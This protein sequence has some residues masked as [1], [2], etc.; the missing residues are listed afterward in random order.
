MI[1]GGGIGGL[2]AANALIRQGLRVSVYEQAAAL[3]EI[4]AGVFVTPNAVRQGVFMVSAT[5]PAASRRT[6]SL[7]SAGV[8][9]QVG[10]T[11]LF[12][13]D[14]LASK[15]LHHPLDDLVQYRLHRFVARCGDFDKHR[16]IGTAPLSASSLDCQKPVSHQLIPMNFNPCGRRRADK[17]R[18]QR[19]GS[20]PPSSVPRRMS[21]HSCPVSG[22]GGDT[23]SCEKLKP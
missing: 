10:F 16:P 14:P 23:A 21:V 12:D 15:Q 2:F 17:C 13:Q 9:G 5:W 8:T 6:R 3:G 4:G 22:A 18:C 19:S 20:V 1:I 11:L 7:A